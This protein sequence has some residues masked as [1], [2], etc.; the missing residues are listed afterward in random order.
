MVAGGT[1]TGLP[2][3]DTPTKGSDGNFPVAES[4]LSNLPFNA[5]SVEFVP[6]GPL[7]WNNVYLQL[8]SVQPL[9]PVIVTLVAWV[10]GDDAGLRFSRTK[11]KSD[12][13]DARRLLLSLLSL[14]EVVDGVQCV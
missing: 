5:M 1:A 13:D 10:S 11:V 4:K 12:D 9:T 3:A 7:S 6:D 14:L 8:S 2:S